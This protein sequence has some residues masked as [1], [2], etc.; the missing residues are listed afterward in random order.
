ME[1]DAFAGFFQPVKKFNGLFVFQDVHLAS[2]DNSNCLIRTDD[3]IPTNR[4][5][6]DV[7]F[8]GGQPV[9]AFQGQVMSLG[10]PAHAPPARICKSESRRGMPFYV[11]NA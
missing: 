1:S 6:Q 2:F 5:N 3:T 11:V 4:N 8:L 10:H 9:N 7:G